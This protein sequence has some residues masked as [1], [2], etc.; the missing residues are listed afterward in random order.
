MGCGMPN[1]SQIKA[2]AVVPTSMRTWQRPGVMQQ[3]HCCSQQDPCRC[4]QV[5]KSLILL[6]PPGNKLTFGAGTSAVARWRM[7]EASIKVASSSSWGWMLM[8]ILVGRC[9]SGAAVSSTKAAS[10]LRG[11]QPAHI[12]NDLITY[13]MILTHS[14]KVQNESECSSAV[15][16]YS[17]D[18]A[19]KIFMWQIVSRVDVCLHIKVFCKTS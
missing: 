1:I 8:C 11:L 9:A 17:H 5:P 19:C 16:M 13:S 12:Q 2:I 10:V 3:V 15:H 6:L 7:V 14:K 4:Q 18:I